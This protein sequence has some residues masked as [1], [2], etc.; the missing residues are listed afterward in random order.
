MWY[1]NDPVTIERW[2][3]NVLYDLEVE[4]PQTH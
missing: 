3:D 2:Y 4:V 1:N